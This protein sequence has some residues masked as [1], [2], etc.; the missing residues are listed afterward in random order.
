MR[1]SKWSLYSPQEAKNKCSDLRAMVEARVYCRGVG[2]AARKFA[3]MKP[4]E[5]RVESFSDNAIDIRCDG[6]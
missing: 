2:F 1:V 4:A 3:C 5:A 6:K